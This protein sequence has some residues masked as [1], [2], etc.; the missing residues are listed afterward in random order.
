MERTLGVYV[1]VPFCERVCPYCDFA[2]VATKRLAPEEEDRY[3]AALL[4]ELAARAP[5]F[6]GLA[7]DTIYL[8]GGTPALLRPEAVARL[9]AGLRGAFG[10]RP[11]EVTLEANP[12]T[13]ERERLAGFRAAGVDRLSLGVQ[14][15]DD[16][17]LRR[18]GRAHRA[19]EAHRTLAAARAAGF[20]NLSLDLIE[21]APGQTPAD[22]ERD[23][24]AALAF[25]PEHLSAYAL[26]LEP[27][28]P[29]HAAAASGRL[30][31]PD[32]DAVA[33]MLERTHARLEAAGL[34]RYEVSSWA[35][36][37]RESLHN[38]RYWRRAPVLGLGV[39]AH[40]TE[41]ASD[42]APFGARAANERGLAAW[43][44]RVEAGGGAEP[45]QREAPDAATARGEAAFLALRTRA[46]LDAARFEAEFGAGPRR[47]FAAAIDA[48][49]AEGLLDEGAAGD[50][51]PTARSWLFAD[52]VATHFVGAPVELTRPEARDTPRESS[53]KDRV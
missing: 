3:V 26:T 33:E 53:S 51:R 35:R 41:P 14:S 38:Q 6:A 22:V 17:T 36:P 39:G 5:R 30:A 13:L 18:L 21:G 32:D 52:A 25:A 11:R 9:V 49:R 20:T 42:E 1:H 43:L 50:L 24:D 34:L 45:P 27:G 12:S 10:G 8:G 16:V 46:G 19:E 29:F 7:L 31:P 44:A 4:G 48:L 37:G 47:F 23:L 15:F 40:S 2:V 28:T